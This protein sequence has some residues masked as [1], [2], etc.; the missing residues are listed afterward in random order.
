MQRSGALSL[1]CPTRSSLDARPAP[2]LPSWAWALCHNMYRPPIS[3]PDLLVPSYC[4]LAMPWRHKVP[5][6]RPRHAIASLKQRSLQSL[7]YSYLVRG[8]IRYHHGV[9]CICASPPLPILVL[10]RACG[11]FRLGE[12]P[13]PP[14]NTPH[15]SG[16]T[17]AGDDAQQ[18]PPCRI[19]RLP[20][21]RLLSLCSYLVLSWRSR[22]VELQMARACNGAPRGP[23]GNA[24]LFPVGTARADFDASLCLGPHGGGRAC[25]AK[26]PPPTDREP[27]RIQGS[28]HCMEG[29]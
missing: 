8:N 24:I 5:R 4:T 13:V 3:C 14:I 29:N 20:Q 9:T 16:P 23:F 19:R 12:A 11:A 22:I 2:R 10:V 6:R 18:R 28:P 1:L 25:R 21:M 27:F 17:K 26:W 7:V 15:L